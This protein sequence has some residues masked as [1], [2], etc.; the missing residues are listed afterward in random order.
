[1]LLLLH[2]MEV[3]NMLFP[4]YL[5]KVTGVLFPQG[6]GSSSALLSPSPSF[7]AK[8]LRAATSKMQFVIAVLLMVAVPKMPWICCASSVNVPAFPATHLATCNRVA[9]DDVL[10]TRQATTPL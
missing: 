1:M 4:M 10:R 9:G 8:L 7:A 6:Q 3:T 5:M 2:G